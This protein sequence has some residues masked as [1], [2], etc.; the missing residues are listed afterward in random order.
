MATKKKP[1]KKAAS[2]SKPKGK[3][4]AAASKGKKT[5]KGGRKPPRRAGPLKSAV[6]KKPRTRAKAPRADT[7]PIVENEAARRL[8]HSMGLAVL[9]KKA[10]DVVILDVRG[11]ASYADYIVLASGES[12]PQV[13]A[14][15]EAI[16]AK[17]K[18][19]GNRVLSREGESPGSWLLLDYGDVVAHLFEQ[20]A[21]AFYDLEGLWADAPREQV[22]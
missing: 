3:R 17:L 12:Q 5:L 16:E 4:P 9:E 10:L 2:K 18:P 19:E 22:K 15:A 21:R 7:R 6:K 1:A 8:A 11:K 14:M 20:E 13:R